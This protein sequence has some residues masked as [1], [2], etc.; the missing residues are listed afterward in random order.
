MF[1]LKPQEVIPCCVERSDAT[2][3]LGFQ[4]RRW[5]FYF[6]NESHYPLEE[7]LQRCRTWLD[8]NQTPLEVRAILVESGGCRMGVHNPQ[9]KAR[10]AAEV[11]EE[12]R[13]SADLVKTHRWRARTFAKSFVGS[14]AVSWLCQRLQVQRQEAVALG[15]QLL[16]QGI[17]AHVLGEQD[18]E[19]G[20]YFYRFSSD[21]APEKRLL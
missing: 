18:F 16:Q 15:R 3:M 14:E 9:L 12:M 21:G 11:F 4:F 19:D 8:S 2:A 10:P 1:I 13:T 7:A 5:A 17:F 20:Q 6:E